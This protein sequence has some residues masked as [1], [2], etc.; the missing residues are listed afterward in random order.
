MC[1]FLSGASSDSQNI[2]EVVKKLEAFRGYYSGKLK[3]LQLVLKKNKD[4][5]VSLFLNTKLKVL[6]RRV[7]WHFLYRAYV[8]S[9][10][11]VKGS[12]FK[13]TLA[14]VTTVA[15]HFKFFQ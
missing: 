3:Y 6:C 2:V 7:L 12:G 10:F 11:K 8:A 13:L 9:W 5:R 14:I 15:L 4:S 1:L